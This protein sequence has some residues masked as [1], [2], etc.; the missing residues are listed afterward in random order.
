[1]NERTALFPFEKKYLKKIITKQKQNAECSA[2]LFLDEVLNPVKTPCFFT[3]GIPCFPR[4]F[5]SV[6]YGT[7]EEAEITLWR[8]KGAVLSAL[9]SRALYYC[10]QNGVKSVFLV[11]DPLS[12]V[13]PLLLTSCGDSSSGVMTL[14]G[15]PGVF[16]QKTYSEYF[17]TC[18][19]RA[20]VE[21]ASEAAVT[22]AEELSVFCSREEEGDTYRLVSDGHELSS[23]RI[24]CFPGSG[25]F[26]LF[27]LLTVPEKRH[28]GYATL[29][30]KEVAER[31][32]PS[33]GRQLILQVSSKNE[34][35]ER[36]YRKL[37]FQTEEQRDYYVIRE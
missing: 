14:N 29:L 36:L 28:M 35:A 10:R 18:D 26:Y 19:L 9:F 33:G 6:F 8:K 20:L 11:V 24:T 12:K 27:D 3:Q 15:L 2:P 34:P 31:L 25:R 32:L 30:L 37:M 4:A 22:S 16:F 5:L 13:Q 1:M 23:C 7:E 21:N 17:L